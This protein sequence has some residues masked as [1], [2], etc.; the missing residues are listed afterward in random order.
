MADRRFA[1]LL[2][3]APAALA[4]AALLVLL[5]A[6]PRPVLGAQHAVTI[7]DDAFTPASITVSVGDT[8]TWTNAGQ[9]PHTVTSDS[10]AF[11][12]QRLEP[13]AVFSHTFT[14][15]GTFTY[16]CDF[17]SNMT[18]QVVV[19][20]GVPAADPAAPA[21]GSGGSA[22]GTTDPVGG[23]AAA[24]GSPTPGSV[25]T[26]AVLPEPLAPSAVFALV[27][28]GLFY[29]TLVVAMTS[30]AARRV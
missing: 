8:V 2:P 20:A 23:A 19:Q 15:A 25:P 30:A 16:R 21:A 5:L 17:H 27:G 22:P 11:D 28:V 14:A 7:I 6:A 13:G 3:Y 12:S 10:G 24:G 9:D 18:G 29:T 1:R 4:P 26:T